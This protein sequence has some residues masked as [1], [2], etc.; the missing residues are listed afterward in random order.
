MN[1]MLAAT[2]AFAGLLLLNTIASMFSTAKRS[3]HCARQSLKRLKEVT[4]DLADS[5]TNG[6]C[7]VINK[8]ITKT[9]L[10]TP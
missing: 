9:S 2:F 7:R 5:C 4:D 6:S 3:N 8:E 10:P 1:L